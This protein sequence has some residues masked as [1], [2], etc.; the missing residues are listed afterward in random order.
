MQEGQVLWIDIALE[1]LQIVAIMKLLGD[2]IRRGIVV[3]VVELG[4]RRRL[5]AA[6]I[7]EHDL[8]YFHA[9]IRSIANA[10]PII[11]G[12]RLA[13]LLETASIAA[14][15]PAVVQT[16]KAARLHPP[17]A[18]IDPPM[19]AKTIDQRGLA[20]GVAKQHQVLTEDTDGVRRIRGE[21]FAQRDRLPISPHHRPAGCSGIGVRDALIVCLLQHRLL[22]VK[23]YGAMDIK[24][25]GL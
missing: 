10:L 1:A 20:V 19:R 12:R 18:Q 23:V 8:A 13:R 24:D 25:G 22:L 21:L 2:E 3:E 7:G 5:A 14:H 15:H 9:G 17:I 4:Q 11:A 16:A 6:H